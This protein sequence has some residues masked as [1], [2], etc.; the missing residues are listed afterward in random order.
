MTRARA[1]TASQFSAALGAAGL[2]ATCRAGLQALKREHAAAVRPRDSR[3]LTG[4]V[5]FEAAH[6]ASE[7]SANFWD[8]GVGLRLTNREEVAVWV[9]VHPASST[10]SVDAMIAKKRWLQQK[11]EDYESL[12]T[13]TERARACAMDTYV[14]IATQGTVSFGPGSTHAQKLAS[15]GITMPKR[16][17]DLP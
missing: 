14:W 1:R 4:S 6:A 16:Y 7:P 15:A 12:G 11:L 17:V 2:G 5:D 10:A 9:E 8:Y 3:R 13:L